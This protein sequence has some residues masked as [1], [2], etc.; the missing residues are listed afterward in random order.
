MI[1][2]F[3]VAAFRW[4]RVHFIIHSSNLCH[5]LGCHSRNRSAED[6]KVLLIR[7][8]YCKRRAKSNHYSTLDFN[9]SFFNTN[10]EAWWKKIRRTDLALQANNTCHIWIQIWILTKHW[11]NNLLPLDDFDLENFRAFAFALSDLPSLQP[12]SRGWFM[13]TL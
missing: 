8:S 9:K 3:N 4:E 10:N 1:T 6:W 2:M 13:S 12:V 5:C 7:V 11:K